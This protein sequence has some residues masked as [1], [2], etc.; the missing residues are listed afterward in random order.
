MTYN[1]GCPLAP[2]P[3]TLRM[4]TKCSGMSSATPKILITMI[5]RM[6]IIVIMMSTI[7]RDVFCNPQVADLP[8]CVL[9]VAGAMRTGKSFL[10][11][12]MVSFAFKLLWSSVRILT[13]K[14]QNSDCTSC[15]K[16]FNYPRWIILPIWPFW[17]LTQYSKT[18]TRHML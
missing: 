12:Q 7:S 1:Q 13:W 9:S 4:I 10:L 5:I 3:A 15:W 16:F 8:A 6:M 11:D 18:S 2:L 14:M 17:Q